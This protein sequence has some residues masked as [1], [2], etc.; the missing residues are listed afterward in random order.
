[1]SLEGE[2]LPGLPEASEERLGGLAIAK[3]AHAAL[4]CTCVL[5]TV[6]DPIIQASSRF[7]VH[8]QERSSRKKKRLA[9]A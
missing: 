1:M 8:G 3:P 4:A 9:A 6:P 7:D 5:V 2:L